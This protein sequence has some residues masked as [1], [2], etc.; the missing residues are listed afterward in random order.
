M[1]YAYAIRK[2]ISGIPAAAL[3]ISLILI[4]PAAAQR[5]IRVL[6]PT[7]ILISIDGF[8]ADYLFKY[9]PKNLLNLAR[10]GVH[11]QWMTPS[12][13]T[14]TFPNH[15]TIATGLYPAKHGIVA[16][17]MFDPEFDAM[18]TLGKREEVQN[19]RWWG[20]E[21]IWVTAEK[22][23]QRAAAY[24]FPGTETKINGF[25]ATFWRE[26]D[27]ETTNETRVDTV[28]EWFDLPGSERPTIFTMYFSDVD[29]AGHEFSPDSEGTKAAVLRVDEMIGRLVEGLKSRGI[30][31][32]VNLILVSDHGMA[33]VPQNNSVVLDDYFDSGLAE[34]VI[35][36]SELVQ[37][38]P[39][40]GK[41]SE[42][43]EAIRSRLPRSVRV[44][45]KEDL[46]A[47]FKWT[48]HRRIPPIVVIPDP[49]W[50]VVNRERFE[51][52][53]E[54]GRLNDVRGSHGYDNLAPEMRALFIASGPAFK[55]RTTILPIRNIEI[56]NLMCSILG[57]DPAPN[58]GDF[59]N[60]KNILK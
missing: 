17:N 10:Q 8:R 32:K 4:I 20:G 18:F 42:I 2:V 24:F 13:P 1:L 37:I 59:E 53:K 29:D 44:Y 9:Q 51:E 35:W 5:Q 39:K 56:Y 14:K 41:T 12:F 22:Q 27:G 33:A 36:V 50:I 34:R 25:Q 46:P 49:G 52:M 57:L 40:E 54:S 3:L 45:R 7:V 19:P 21:P 47:R 6:K 16:N 48:D 60:V 11:A 55:K 23:G 28:L 58:D 31:K 30:E 38:W 43:Y 15:Y 26:Y